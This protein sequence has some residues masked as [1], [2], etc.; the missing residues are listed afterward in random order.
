MA[1]KVFISCGQSNSSER[2]VATQLS[3]WFLSQG[4]NPYVA[5]QTQSILEVNAGIIRELKS[6]DFYLFINFRREKIRHR[7]FLPS[8]KDFFRG[9][10]F[11]NQELAIAYAM[12]FDNML[13]VNQIGVRRD[14]LF[15][16]IGVNTPEFDDYDQVLPI[17]QTA[18]TSAGWRPL[19]S[20]NLIC[21]NIHWGDHV[22]Y[23]DNT[24]AR[25]VKVL[26]IDI[27]NN[28]PDQGA[29][30]TVARLKSITTNGITTIAQDRSHLKCSGSPVYS[31]TI[32]PNDHI[33]FDL[34]SIDLNNQSNIYLHSA[35]DV[36]P[37]VPLI[38]MTGT[39]V[40]EYEIF[41]ESFPPISVSVSLINTGNEATST[42][43]IV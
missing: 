30:N 31:N 23:R 28:R 26:H 43:S 9:S 34:L 3:D 25:N 41:A 13:F 24:G 35:L 37:R 2:Q 27:L 10:V 4:Y 8:R 22:I 18:V 32:W 39:Y 5:I 1:G 12:G 29:T 36:F 16:Y 11:T 40:L 19:Y 17:V 42:A 14:G 38:T 33:A 20:R 21:Q 6:S 7:R 15:G